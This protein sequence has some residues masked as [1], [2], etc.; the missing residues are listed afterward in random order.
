MDKLAPPDVFACIVH[1]LNRK[2]E[3][4]GFNLGQGLVA[5]VQYDQAWVQ[6]MASKGLTKASFKSAKIVDDATEQQESL[7]GHDT[8]RWKY[9]QDT[10]KSELVFNERIVYE[11][12][13]G[14]VYQFKQRGCF[15]KVMSLFK[16]AVNHHHRLLSLKGLILGASNIE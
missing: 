12:G 1:V 14:L 5:I 3:S 7:L 8:Q 15:E 2:G 10:F 4:S 11:K 13:H 9:L 16:T 6:K